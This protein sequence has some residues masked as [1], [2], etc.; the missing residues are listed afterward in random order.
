MIPKIFHFIWIGDESQRPDNC[1][2]TWRDRHPDW[3]FR[4]W[5][6]AELT[7]RA[8]ANHAH[9]EAM[10]PRELNGVA[11][12]MRWEILFEHGGVAIDADSVCVRKLDDHLLEGQAFACWENEIARPG[13]IAA[14]YFGC[15]AGNPLVRA[16]IEDIAAS[17]SVIDDVAAKTVGAQRLTDCYREYAYSPLRIHPS[18]YFMP[19]HFTGQLYEG[20]GPIYAHQLWGSM[21]KTYDRIHL[22]VLEDTPDAAPT[23]AAKITVPATMTAA[24][25]TAGTSASGW[26]HETHTLAASP[27]A[28]APRFAPARAD[29][30]RSG[31]APV[32]APVNPPANER[33]PLGTEHD[34]A[35]VQRV[36]VGAELAGLGRLDVFASLC[37]GKRVLHIGCAGGKIPDPATSLHLALEPFCAQLDGFDTVAAL[38]PLRA[39]ARG[40]LFSD[41]GAISE[42]Y[43]VVIVPEVL[44][45][46][47][48]A[49]AFL[50]QIETIEA[51]CFLISVSDAS[52]R[53]SRQF[54]FVEDTQTVVEIVH[55]DHN[56]WYTPY[57]LSNTIRKYSAL[58]IERLFFFDE[59][60]ILA[61]LSKECLQRAA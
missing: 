20:Q 10:L 40:A 52:Q 55:P 11:D 58:K 29:A 21:F 9:I 5:G 35:F 46:V 42:A 1:M 56:V 36:A 41:W 47:P 6:N 34:P 50:A 3:Q 27:T 7:T 18:H 51:S 43:D 23:V 44:E 32:R 16:I 45:Q 38:A 59:V 49:A 8:W 17:A 24:S 57:T 26:A 30:P 28:P 53:R 19:K 4:L 60:S 25:T 31:P 2:Q 22:A 54:D 61:L 13:L 14:G 12:M 15:D 33:A 39:H 37:A 48:D